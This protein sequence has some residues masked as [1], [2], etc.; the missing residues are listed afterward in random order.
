[1]ARVVRRVGGSLVS[2]LLPTDENLEENRSNT[3]P[4]RL[5]VEDALARVVRR[6]GGSLVSDLLPTHE[7]L[8][9]N[10]DIVDRQLDGERTAMLVFE[11]ATRAE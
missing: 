8:E 2:D 6:V 3:S 7:N 9:E 4:L 11:M 10:A 1:L 5:S